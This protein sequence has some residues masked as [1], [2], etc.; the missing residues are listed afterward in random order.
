MP[1]PIEI[2]SRDWR[3]SE[4][5]GSK[6]FYMIA[7]NSSLASSPLGLYHPPDQLLSCSAA[8]PGTSVAA[9]QS[10]FHPYEAI[11]VPSETGFSRVQ[12][13]VFNGANSK[14]S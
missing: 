12:L 9:E 10:Q 2:A 6:L 1:H 3:F 8:S 11:T 14:L 4:T 7:L 13:Y 5:L